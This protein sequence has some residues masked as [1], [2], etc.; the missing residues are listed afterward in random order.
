[1]DAGVGK[2]GKSLRSSGAL[3]ESIAGFNIV[4]WSVAVA[5]AFYLPWLEL[6]VG[7][8]LLVPR[9]RVGAAWVA[10]LLFTGF[11]LLWVLTW[12]RGINVACGCFGSGGETSI[13]LGLARAAGLAVMGWVCVKAEHKRTES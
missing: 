5:G 6:V 2:R 4:P 9:W 3:A 12:A 7:V 1:L 13:A 11:A 10:A 8:G